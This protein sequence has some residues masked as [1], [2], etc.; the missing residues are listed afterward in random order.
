VASICLFHSSPSLS[1]WSVEL[2]ERSRRNTAAHPESIAAHTF[3]L[4]LLFETGRLAEAHSTLQLIMNLREDEVNKIC[5][6]A[7]TACAYHYLGQQ[8]YSE[9]IDCYEQ[10]CSSFR[11]ITKTGIFSSDVL[12]V[13]DSCHFRLAQTYNRVMNQRSGSFQQEK[14]VGFEEAYKKIYENLTTVIRE[15]LNDL[16][17]A[18]A[19][20]ELIESHE[21]CSQ[22]GARL[23]SPDSVA[24]VDDA[25]KLAPKDPYVLEHCGKYYRRSAKNDTDRMRAAEI[26]E[27]C[28]DL[29]DGKH[30]AWHQQGLIYNSLWY[31]VKKDP[32]YSVKKELKLLADLYLSKAEMCME[33]ACENTGRQ[34]GLYLSELAKSYESQRKMDEAEKT[35]MEADVLSGEADV[36]DHHCMSIIYRAWAV[37]LDK[38]IQMHPDERREEKLWP[39]V[40]KQYERRFWEVLEKNTMS[41]SSF[42]GLYQNKGH[43]SSRTKP[44][45]SSILFWVWSYASTTVMTSLL[46]SW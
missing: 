7:E 40:E 16:H 22:T 27:K 30:V 43:T 29:C 20:I 1:P 28:T 39:C 44:W 23:E 3:E 24:S 4:R 34:R 32:E 5:C 2:I 15:S 26:F 18:R 21:R 42:T 45:K 11:E 38:R 37:C 12:S 46:S 19:M 33:K 25:L 10:V 8:F 35:F 17:R 6:K 9:A 36:I 13:I 41:T 14:G 31:S